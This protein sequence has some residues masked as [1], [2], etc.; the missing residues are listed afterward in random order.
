M[1]GDK[2]K[3]SPCHIKLEKVG[4]D[5]Y[6][7]DVHYNIHLGGSTH[8]VVRSFTGT[9]AEASKFITDLRLVIASN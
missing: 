9:L 4:N 1:A 8:P 6:Q 3:L 7:V 2:A 5:E